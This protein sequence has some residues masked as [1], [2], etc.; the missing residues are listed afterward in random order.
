MKK[1]LKLAAVFMAAG[2]FIGLF[3]FYFNNKRLDVAGIQDSDIQMYSE[4][5]LLYCIDDQK[6]VKAYGSDEQIY[7]A[8]LTKIMTAVVALDLLEERLDIPMYIPKDCIR[9]LR[10]R[11]A[12]MAGF[13]PGEI[14]CSGDCLYAM[15]LASGADAAMALAV[16]L[17]GSEMSFVDLMNQKAEKLQMTGTHFTNVTGL[18][19]K[20]HYSTLNDIQKLLVYALEDDTFRK[21]FTTSIYETS[22]TDEHPEGIVLESTFFNK[23]SVYTLEDL[24][25]LGGKTG[26]TDE[27]GLCLATLASCHQKEYILITSGAKAKNAAAA[28]HVIDAVNVYSELN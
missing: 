8:S 11:N 15:M 20:N 17:C 12:S 7:P 9:E 28:F 18:H 2:F 16:N 22:K 4:E 6:I 14:L 10:L 24:T 25:L 21:I 13:E 26:Y 1:K 3:I 19:E 23:V 5:M 27:A